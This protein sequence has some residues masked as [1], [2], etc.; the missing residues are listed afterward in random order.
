MKIS[1]PSKIHKHLIAKEYIGGLEITDTAL[2]FL[3]F[4]PY[5]TDKI[6]LSFESDLEPGT[7]IK[8]ELKKPEALKEVL[9]N[10][11]R[12]PALK[13]IKNLYTILSLESNIVYYKIFDLPTVDRNSILSAVE[14]NT[15]MLSPI[16]FDRVYS[17]WELIDKPIKSDSFKLRVFSVFAEKTIVDAYVK[18]LD[19]VGIMPLAVEFNGLSLLRFF[20][21]YNIFDNLEKNYLGIYISANGLEFILGSKN[22]LEFNF[23]QTW[24]DAFNVLG[25]DSSELQKGIISKE[26]FIKIFDDNLQKVI[27]FYFTRFQ[28][29]IEKVI[30]VT[31]LH[32]DDLS[33]L[34]R[35]RYNL[36]VENPIS[37]IK[38]I[39]PGYYFATGAAL[40]GLIPRVDDVGVSL[41][42]V[43]TEEE[44]RRS[45]TTNFLGLW[46]KIIVEVGVVLL[47]ISIGLNIFLSYSKTNVMKDKELLSIQFDRAQLEKLSQQSKEFNANIAQ[48]I[49][50]KKFVKDWAPVFEAWQQAAE[51]I[52]FKSL[53]IPGAENNF[54]FNGWTTSQSE[55]IKFRDALLESG[56]F[57]DLDIPL[58]SIIQQKNKVEFNLKGKIKL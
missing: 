52:H 45:R 46:L 23:F 5:K 36:N 3:L 25:L 39:T 55:M 51:N 20:S 28:E 18:V 42:A 53:I 22:S 43:G 54:S 21:H 7:V 34:I 38:D 48:A 12:Q 32:F 57:T 4:D 58:Q 33:N 1:P 56:Y 40:R 31:P 41:M 24:Q 17:D 29:S 19:E 44:Y 49:E 16:P 2:H 37:K 50:A 35:D 8:G 47:L 27:T 14:L 30:L 13:K 15:R 6:I 11:R 10:L 9:L 26:N